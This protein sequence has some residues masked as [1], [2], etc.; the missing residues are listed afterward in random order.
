M[1]ELATVEFTTVKAPIGTVPLKLPAQT[2]DITLQPEPTQDQ[3]DSGNSIIPNAS[4]YTYK[5]AGG[6]ESVLVS[7]GYY[8][9][10]RPGTELLQPSISVPKAKVDIQ[11]NKKVIVWDI[12]TSGT[13]LFTSRVILCSMWDIN[14]PKSTIVSLYA[15]D[16]EELYKEIAA[17]FNQEVPDILVGYNISFELRFAASRLMKYQIPCPGLWNAQPLELMEIGI[18]GTTKALRSTQSAGTLEDWETYLFNDTKP[19]TIEECFEGLRQ[20]RITEFYIRN[21]LCTSTEGDM[22]KVYLYQLGGENQSGTETVITNVSGALERAGGIEESI[23]IVC[24]QRNVYDRS[25]SVHNCF[26]CGSPLP[27]PEQ[28]KKDI[29][30]HLGTVLPKLDVTLPGYTGPKPE[31]TGTDK[32]TSKATTEATTTEITDDQRTRINAIYSASTTKT[33]SAADKKKVAQ[34]YAETSA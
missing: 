8:D 17:Y 19:Y 11:V 20:G 34:I 9:K 18:K 16:E 12:E 25:E 4:Q 1:A 23:C 29:D 2:F 30:A 32:A 28:S 24:K 26:V 31:S 13:D 3:I 15:Q 33:L 7:E 6:V 14:K 10:V 21:K 27:T 5:P 22:Y